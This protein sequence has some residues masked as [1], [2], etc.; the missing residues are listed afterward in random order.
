AKLGDLV[1]SPE[2]FERVHDDEINTNEAGFD[3]PQHAL[4]AGAFAQVAAADA[5]IAVAGDA[6]PWETTALNRFV[7][8]GELLFRRAF[9]LPGI[10]HATVAQEAIPLAWIILAFQHGKSPKAGRARG[11]GFARWRGQ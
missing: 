6:P 10:A 7:D 1:G 2:P 9:V 8:G 3:V 11:T 4:K 5:I